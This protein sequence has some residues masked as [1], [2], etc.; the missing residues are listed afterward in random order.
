MKVIVFNN[1]MTVFFI[2]LLFYYS[3]QFINN[4]NNNIAFSSSFSS[5][6]D[7]HRV[8][9]MAVGDSIGYNINYED[10]TNLDSIIPKNTDIFIFNL[11]GIL[12]AD[13][14]I[15]DNSLSLEECKGFPSEQSNFVAD[16]TFADYLKLAPITI[17]NLANNH[18][19]EC[20]PKG[21][22]ETK[23]VLMEKDI[24]SVGAGQNLKEACEPLVIQSK[25]GLRIVF[26]S[27][28][29]IL[30]NL[31]SA[32]TNR[33]GGA[34]IDNCNHDYSK[35]RMQNQAD[36]IIASIHL[37]IWSPDVNKEQIDVIQYLFDSGIDIVIGHSPHIPQAILKTTTA[38]D[39]GKEK[40]A[41]FSLGNFILNPDYNMPFEAHTTIVPELDIDTEINIMNVTIYPIRIDNEGIPH[42]EERWDNEIISKIAMTSAE[43]FGTSININENIG[44]LLVKIKQ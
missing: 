6:S 7:E 38:T 33:A 24:L 8:S 34:S 5:S 29:F 37:G 35:I 14:S 18:I 3:S 20:G 28:N 44:Q 26:V 15:L 1:G 36:L 10:L 30:E 40:L 23:R 31:V 39:E 2:L 19:F 4:N 16:S 12:V 42:L 11:E 21:I 22:Q 32:Q 43:E 25:E 13:S 17:A 27:Y 41:F 9:L